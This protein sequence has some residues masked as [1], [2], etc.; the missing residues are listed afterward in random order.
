M[1]SVILRS[2]AATILLLALQSGS[3]AHSAFAQQPQRDCT[4]RKEPNGLIRGDRVPSGCV[5][6]SEDRRDEAPARKPYISCDETIFRTPN[7]KR[8]VLTNCVRLSRGRM[9]IPY[10]A[11]A[12]ADEG[13][14]GPLERH[15][16][17]LDR[18]FGPLDRHFGPVQRHFGP[19]Q[20]HFGRTRL[21]PV[22][23]PGA[24]PKSP[25]N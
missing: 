23:S 7:P 25:P 22:G 19:L 3:P 21:E 17:P 1:D 24:N 12:S 2:V 8:S 20:R 11:V 13:A 15:F 4:V 14:F 5:L 6:Q 10:G 18:H 9:I 16:E